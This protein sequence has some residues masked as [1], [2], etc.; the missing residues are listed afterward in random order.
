M[1]VGRAAPHPQA[2]YHQDQSTR[3]R[4]K[5]ATLTQYRRAAQLVRGETDIAARTSAEEAAQQREEFRRRMLCGLPVAQ[6]PPSR[7]NSP[8][9]AEKDMSLSTRSHFHLGRL[10]LTEPWQR[11]A[12]C[13]WRREKRAKTDGPVRLRRGIRCGPAASL[14][15]SSKCTKACL[16]TNDTQCIIQL[17][18]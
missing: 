1:A 7:R 5:A 14:R 11:C 6:E 16:Y 9:M 18:R 12:H 3:T 17:E 10:L 8:V 13:R 15:H 4:P 2:S